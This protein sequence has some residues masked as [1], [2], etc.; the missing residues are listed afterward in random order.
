MKIIRK[1]QQKIKIPKIPFCAS[2]FSPHFPRD[3]GDF[4]HLGI[5][6]LTHP[7]HAN[8][9]TMQP[10]PIQSFQRREGFGA[11]WGYAPA[12]NVMAAA[13]PNDI[14]WYLPSRLALSGGTYV[15]CFACMHGLMGIICSSTFWRLLGP[16]LGEAVPFPS[17]HP[18]IQAEW[19][20]VMAWE[21]RAAPQLYGAGNVQSWQSS[22]LPPPLRPRSIFRYI[23]PKRNSIRQYFVRL[24]RS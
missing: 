17:I 15:A 1:M 10:H 4:P 18:S 24:N 5:S 3:F 14:V 16:F 13:A 11:Y 6:P 12:R 21:Y 2:K 9:K 19:T 8:G 20:N 7:G 23:K 22:S